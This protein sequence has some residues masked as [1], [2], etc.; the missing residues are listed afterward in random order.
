MRIFRF[1]YFI[2]RGRWKREKKKGKEGRILWG[3]ETEGIDQNRSMGGGEDPARYCIM[4]QMKREKKGKEE[5]IVG[6][7]KQRL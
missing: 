4:K 1:R 7:K 2:F 5:E 6:R 3:E